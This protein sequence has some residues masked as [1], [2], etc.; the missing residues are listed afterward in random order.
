MNPEPRRR[1][2]PLAVA[3]V[4]IALVTVLA[5][6]TYVLYRMRTEAPAPATPPAADDG[7]IDKAVGEIRKWLEERRP[8][9]APPVAKAPPPAP[10]KPTPLPPVAKLPPAPPGAASMR[11]D[12]AD[13]RPMKEKRDYDAGEAQGYQVLGDERFVPDRLF[14]LREQL[15]AKAGDRLAGKR[16][17]VRQLISWYVRTPK[18]ALVDVG[19]GMAPMEP[20]KVWRISEL[21]KAAYWVICDVILVV[22]GQTAIG[23]GTQGFDHPADLAGRHERALVAAIEGAIRALPADAP[24]AS[25]RLFFPPPA[26]G[27]SWRYNVVVEP[28]LWQEATLTY[29]TVRQG[30]DLAVTTEFRHAAGTM[31]FNLGVFAAAHPSHANVRFPGF[32]LHAAYFHA[33]EPRQAIVWEWYWQT[34]DGKTRPGRIKRYV[35]QAKEWTELRLQGTNHPALRIEATLSYIEDG[36]VAA[37]ARE[38]IWYMPAVRQVAKVVREGRTPDEGATRIVAEL[39]EFK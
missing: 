37:E 17:E 36:R 13:M 27:R 15:A 9:P 38:T 25:E 12:L 1:F 29:R 3:F 19:P 26:A 14:V 23:R 20:E 8:Q 34:P 31:S 22:D 32:F 11:F 16:V 28:P 2:D 21:R 4:S 35:G 30:Q 5:V 18:A 33:L 7:S 39:V 24:V 6:S 10:M